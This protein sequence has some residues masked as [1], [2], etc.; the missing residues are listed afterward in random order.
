MRFILEI[1]G[2]LACFTR[3]ELKV[4]RVSYPVITPSAARNI[5]MAI[6]WKP[7]IRW[8]VLKI[9]ILKPIQ[10]TNI[11]RNE[12]GTKMSERSGSLYIEDNRQQ[13]ASM[14][15][16]DVAYRIHA[17]FDMTSEAGESDNYVKFAEM[18]KRRA[19]KGQYFHQPYLGCR[20]FPCDFRLL[21]KA[22][23]GLPLEDITQDFGF[24]LYDMDFSKSDPRDSNNAEPMFYQCKAVNGVITVPPADSEEVKR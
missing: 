21:E 18:F 8:K 24:M 2:D 10:W 17:D 6:L 13:R 23:D 14:L 12:V 9:E 4:E 22:E 20:E 1:S 11:R 19:K 16:K 5:L 3:S 15:L 7:A